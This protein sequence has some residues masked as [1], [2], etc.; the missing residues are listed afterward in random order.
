M[1]ESRE[2]RNLDK[3]NYDNR[4]T[5]KRLFL[6]SFFLVCSVYFTQAQF[7]EYGGGIGTLNY[8][9]DL[10]RGYQISNSKPAVSLFYRLNFTPYFSSRFALT[11]GGLS[12]SDSNPIDP[13]AVER[14]ASFNIN[15]GEISGAFEY[16]FLDYKTEKSRVKF[17]PY[18]MVGFGLFKMYGVDDP[19]GNYNLIQPA[20]PIGA[21]IKHLIGKRFSAGFEF[22]ARKTFF[23]YLDN[24]SDGDQTIKNYQYGNP[25]DKDWYFFTGFSISY[26]LWDI[27][28][29]FPYVPN[30]AI[31]R[32]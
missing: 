1:E 21:G 5:F 20:L 11:Y 13:F 23:D 26:I 2:K 9:G 14:N 12:G 4:Y 6:T 28:C 8:S 3:L 7:I 18:L 22:S 27:P 17:S 16:H 19:N 30:R 31:M 32:Q 25:N 24:I 10:I 15:I 29:P